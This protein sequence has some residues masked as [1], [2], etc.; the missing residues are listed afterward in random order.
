[1]AGVVVTLDEPEMGWAQMQELRGALLK[2]RAATKTSIAT[3]T[4][5]RPG[6]TCWPP[7]ATRLSIVPTGE[8]DLRGL[9]MESAYVKGLL[10]SSN[11]RPTSSTSANT[12]A[13][14]NR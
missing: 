10:D 2:V 9:F 1:M 7:P 13:R 5:R 11:S 12:R 3:S 14:P 6:N 8:I 4:P